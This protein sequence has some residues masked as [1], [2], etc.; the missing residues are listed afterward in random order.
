MMPATEAPALDCP[1]S[2]G[3]RPSQPY[4][5]EQQSNTQLEQTNGAAQSVLRPLCLLSALAAQRHV[6]QGLIGDL[7][8][9]IRVKEPELAEPEPTKPLRGT[10][11]RGR[12]ASFAGVTWVGVVW[13]GLD[14]GTPLGNLA[15][16]Q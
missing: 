8:C 4:T 11:G 3:C 12:A 9:L 16:W 14:P 6:I 15:K 5:I 10:Q 1:D 7:S 13:A 2:E